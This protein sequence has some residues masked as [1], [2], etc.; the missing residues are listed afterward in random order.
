[1]FN[2]KLVSLLGS[3]LEK[4]VQSVPEQKS[5]SDIPYPNLSNQIENR[6]NIFVSSV[7]KKVLERFSIVVEED[8]KHSRVKN[9][10]VEPVFR[11]QT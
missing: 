11:I 7:S 5:V 10:I 9:T 2:M 4:P 8:I 6:Y 1:M 3:T